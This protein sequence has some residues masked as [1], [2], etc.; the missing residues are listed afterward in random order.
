MKEMKLGNPQLVETLSEKHKV[1]EKGYNVVIKE[2]TQKITANSMKIKRYDD[3]LDRIDFSHV[4]SKYCSKSWKGTRTKHLQCLMLTEVKH[5]GVRYGVKVRCAM[6]QWYR[7]KPG[8][9]KET[10]KLTVTEAMVEKQIK[11]IPNWKARRPDGVHGYWF[12]SIKAVRPVL[13]ALLNQAL[14]SVNVPEG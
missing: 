3:S 11:K 12:K 8:Y 2:L 14:Q 13:A 9:N 5:S 10:R 1:R 7:R 6:A 4:M